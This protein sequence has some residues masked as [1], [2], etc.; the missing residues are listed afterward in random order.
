MTAILR[1]RAEATSSRTKSFGSSRRRAPERDGGPA[2]TYHRQK[3][4]AGGHIIIDGLAE[5]DAWVDA[6]NIHE[7]RIVA[8]GPDQVIE[9]PS[10]FTFRIV[11]AIADKDC[12]PH[13]TS[14]QLAK[15]TLFFSAARICG[16]RSFGNKELCQP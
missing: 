9:Q 11:P 3:H 2:W 7:N 16:I 4:T 8:E 5:I 1:A 14:V 6:G 10:R 15:S 12:T 13:R